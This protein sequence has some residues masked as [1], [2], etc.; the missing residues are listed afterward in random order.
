MP[1][2]PTASVVIPSYNHGAFVEAAAC[3]VLASE[4]ASGDSLELLIVDDGST[5]DS[6]ARLER[7]RDDP[8]V[9]NHFQ[10]NR[11][12]HDALNRGVG[13]SRGE[14]VF[15]L[16]SDDLYHP[17]RVRRVLERFAEDPELNMLASWLDVI[18]AE[19]SHL[20]IK[21]AWHDMPPWPPPSTGPGLAATGDPRLALLET[22]YVS[23]TSNLA[24]RRQLYDG[25]ARF[26]PLRYAH[27]W[28]FLLAASER[29]RLDVIEE[30]LVSYRIHATNTI[31]EGEH[32]ARAEGRM[33]FEILWLV[34]RHAARVLAEHAGDEH[35]ATDLWHRF[36]NRAPRFDDISIL[37]RL[38][39]L[40]GGDPEPP[41]AYEALIGEDHPFRRR[42]VALLGRLRSTVGHDHSR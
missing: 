18:D 6:R 20:G 41:A 32:Q 2:A 9:K 10:E 4:L 8:R 24:F 36:W 7:F 21:R 26:L 37:S 33:R 13:A 1:S 38:V 3:S 22:N 16:N 15:I 35:T 14:I 5:D 29:G 17:S 11:G 40:R 30:P 27:D 23:T 34:A 42:A 31:R 12:A 28:D 39:A 25:G 19:G